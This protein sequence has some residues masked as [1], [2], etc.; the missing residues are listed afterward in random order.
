MFRTILALF[1]SALLSCDVPPVDEERDRAVV[2][3]LTRADEPLLRTR[4]ALVAAKY[5]AMTENDHAFVRGALAV[6]AFDVTSGP[7]RA[8]RY[9]RELPL[10]R[11]IGDA[12][13]ENFGTL[14]HRDGALSLEPNDFDAA[15]QLPFSWDVRRLASSLAVAANTAGL[16]R[17]ACGAVAE[18]LALGYAHGIARAVDGGALD[19]NMV[20]G[21]GRG[22]IVLD[23]LFARA[24]KDARKREELDELTVLDGNVRRFKRG[25]PL[26]DEPDELVDLP[27]F[28]MRAIPTLILD[29][30]ATLIDP[31]DIVELTVHDMVRRYGAGVGSLP[32]IRWL[33]LLRGPSDD[34]SDDVIVELKEVFESNVGSP[35]PPGARYAS[36]A[37]RVLDG[38]AAWSTPDADPLWSAAS[39]FGFTFQMRTESEAHKS[40]RVSRLT[41]ALATVEALADLARR[42]GVRLAHVH[43]TSTASER[44][45]ANSIADAIRDVVGFAHEQRDFAVAYADLVARDRLALIRVRDARGPWLGADS[46]QARERFQA[47]L[48]AL[49]GDRKVEP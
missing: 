16:D 5:A 46:A 44:A 25:R 7:L 14:R 28:V 23:D 47:D 18:A 22:S 29:A 36:V 49:L 8:T 20:P 30:S 33:A 41:G 26:P 45:P 1:A 38:R 21:P 3:V 42:L 4:P 32:R 11:S 27:P 37:A 12:H 6:Y 31:P 13:L 43:A 24:E 19:D 9:T 48:A 35:L 2:S 10:V 34:P 17:A 39:A 15:D 40:L